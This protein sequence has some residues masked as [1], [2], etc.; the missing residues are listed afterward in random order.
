MLLVRLILAG[1]DPL[2]GGAHSFVGAVDTAHPAARAAF[3]LGELRHG[4]L[5]V[6]VSGFL[7]FDRHGPADPL[8]T[9]QRRDVLPGFACRCV[10]CQ[11]FLQ[12]SRQ[13][14]DRSAR[15]FCAYHALIVRHPRRPINQS[16]LLHT[17]NNAKIL[18]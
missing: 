9:S 4:S 16:F 10:C 12:V 15:E 2:L 8:I 7:L 1:E 3:A 18:L 11:G 14:V 17:H 6:F 5:N 13:F